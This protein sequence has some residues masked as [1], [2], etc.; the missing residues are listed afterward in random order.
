MACLQ[1]PWDAV[2]TTSYFYTWGNFGLGLFWHHRW[3]NRFI[4]FWDMRSH[5]L[6]LTILSCIINFE[7]WRLYFISL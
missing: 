2:F 6:W 1:E 4:H 3:I 7:H 5:L